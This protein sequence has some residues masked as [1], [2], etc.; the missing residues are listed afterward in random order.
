[1]MLTESDI[2]G[3]NI[4]IVDDREENVTLLEQLLRI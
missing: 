4:L 3:A 2:L 1:M